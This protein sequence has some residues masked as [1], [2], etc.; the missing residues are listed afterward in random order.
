MNNKKEDFYQLP[1]IDC[2][3]IPIC[4]Q[5]SICV[6]PLYTLSA[7]CNLLYNYLIRNRG[8]HILDCEHTEK[9]YDFFNVPQRRRTY[10]YVELL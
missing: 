7:K 8:T 2:I 9:F 6:S 5:C 10:Y 4:K 1:C 3:C